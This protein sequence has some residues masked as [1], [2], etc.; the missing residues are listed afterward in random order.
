M[1]T[2]FRTS[3]IPKK[4]LAAEAPRASSSGGGSV[5][6]FFAIGTII[7]VLTFVGAG[8][9]YL[10]RVIIEK[11]IAEKSAALESAKKAF[12]PSFIE[13]ARRFDARINAARDLLAAHTVVSP[14]FS[15]LSGETL[16]TIRL[17]NFAYAMGEGSPKITLKG[18]ARAA[19]GSAS[20]YSSVALQSDAFIKNQKILNPAFSDLKL[21]GETDAVGFSFSGGIAE[22]ILRYANNLPSENLLKPSAASSSAPL[23]TSSSSTSR[24]N[25]RRER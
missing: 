23:S 12:E 3:F 22:N 7:F 17:T 5:N 4:T 14:V 1:E 18:E 13:V 8:S 11:S 16:Q 9:V 24:P 10:Y 20:G 6:L 21:Q 2:K 15:L 19:K 25:T